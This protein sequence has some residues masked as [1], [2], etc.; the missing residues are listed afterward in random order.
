MRNLDKPNAL[1]QLDADV[2][3]EMRAM[4]R[5][6]IAFARAG[7]IAR[8]LSCDSVQA[9]GAMQRVK[10]QLRKPK[11]SRCPIRIISRALELLVV[12]GYIPKHRLKQAVR[13]ATKCEPA[14]KP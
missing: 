9:L 13:I 5:N 2:L 8:R 6:G 14:L 7:D 10:S 3:K 12:A 4:R 1:K 11:I